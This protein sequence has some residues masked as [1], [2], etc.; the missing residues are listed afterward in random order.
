MILSEIGSTPYANQV[1]VV[2]K[3]KM[4]ILWNTLC[5]NTLFLLIVKGFLPET[6]QHLENRI[7]QP[8]GTFRQWYFRNSRPGHKEGGVAERPMERCKSAARRFPTLPGA[9]RTNGGEPKF[10]RSKTRRNVIVLWNLKIEVE[11]RPFSMARKCKDL[12]SGEEKEGCLWDS[13]R[14]STRESRL[15]NKRGILFTGI[16]LGHP[17]VSERHGNRVYQSLP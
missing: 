17:T 10:I 11:K 4:K 13:P 5:F 16:Q 12:F 2:G 14:L 9:S 3:R 15:L 7:V 8:L 1:G 6:T